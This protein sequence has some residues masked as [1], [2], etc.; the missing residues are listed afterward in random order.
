MDVAL[1]IAYIIEPLFPE[2]P[3]VLVCS[4]AQ[5]S[6]ASPAYFPG[7]ISRTPSHSA[8]LRCL[9]RVLLHDVSSCSALRCTAVRCGVAIGHVTVFYCGVRTAPPQ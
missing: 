5:R 7:T 3:F 4:Q 2:P 6:S 8:T 1:R 9:L